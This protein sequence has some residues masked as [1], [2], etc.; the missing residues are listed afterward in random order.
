MNYEPLVSVVIPCFN[1]EAWISETL[2]SVFKQTYSNVEVIV[3]DDGS[4]DDT[5]NIVLNYKNKVHYYYQKNKGPSAARNLGVKKSKGEYIAFLDSDDLWELTKIS[6]QIKF[7][8]A[9]KDI[10]LVFSN[11]NIMNEEGVI[12]YTHYNEVPSDKKEIIK[13]FF[14]GRITMNTPTIVARKDSILTIGGFDEELPL[15]EDHFF[16]M[17]M[18]QKYNIYHFKEPLVNRRV[19]QQ[20]MS[21]SIN[22]EKIFELNNPFLI[23]S[24]EL[25]PYLAKYRKSVYSKTNASIGKGYWKSGYY[26]KGSKYMLKA[27]YYNPLKLRNYI[28]LLL[29]IFRVKLNN[30]NKMK[31]KVRTMFN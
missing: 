12:L 4:T 10:H 17:K 26:S 18:A 19:S 13:Y 21:N 28:F 15:R 20:S 22:V 1:S 2:L 9:N 14:S 24:I 5:K 31:L 23:K 8:K 6:K 16:L 30:L 25:F 11:V 7:L 3:I 29:I 27:I